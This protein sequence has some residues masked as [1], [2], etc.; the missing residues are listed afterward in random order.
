MSRYKRRTYYIDRATAEFIRKRRLEKK[1]EPNQLGVTP[2][3]IQ[4]IEKGEKAFDEATLLKVAAKLDIESKDLMKQPTF[5]EKEENRQS[6]RKIIHDV[7]TTFRVRRNILLVGVCVF[8]IIGACLVIYMVKA[9]HG[10]I[11]FEDGF[12]QGADKWQVTTQNWG[13]RREATG[14]HVYCVRAAGDYILAQTGLLTWQDYVLEVDVLIMSGSNDGSGNIQFRVEKD[15]FPAYIYNFFYD[16]AGEYGGELAKETPNYLV[17]DS[18]SRGLSLNQWH[19]IQ[20]EV[21]ED[22]IKV[23][24]DGDKEPC[25]YV[26]DDNPIE[27]GG[28]A[29]GAG[30]VKYPSDEYW[31]V[32]FDNVRVTEV[33]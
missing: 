10:E 16:P 19:H 28:I 12:E 5:I 30:M 9:N 20:I 8:F 33:K 24:V 3:T 23:F 6:E 26:K 18:T 11:L 29:L 27:S 14:N 2:R 17:L 25:L 21:L 4:S 31:E 1:L 32:C 13:I 22:E 7:I 15:L